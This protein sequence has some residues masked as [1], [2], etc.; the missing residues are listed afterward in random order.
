MS[1][2]FQAAYLPDAALSSRAHSGNFAGCGQRK[3]W[4][5][6]GALS[7]GMTP[8]PLFVT[9]PA[10]RNPIG[11]PC[12]GRVAMTGAERARRYRKLAKKRRRARNVEWYSPRW[13][14]DLAVE[15]MGEIDLDPASCAARRALADAPW[16][17]AVDPI[18]GFYLHECRPATASDERPG[19]TGIP[20]IACGGGSP[21][22]WRSSRISIGHDSGKARRTGVHR[23]G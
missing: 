2:K 15:V 1:N 12:V 9:N 4:A 23:H 18:E 11:R 22:S 8:R 19:V 21:K 10:S 5:S 6:R 13:L 17:A 20:H 3:A 16:E 14:I 7:V